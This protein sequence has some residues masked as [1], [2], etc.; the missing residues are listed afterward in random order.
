[1]IASKMH[2]TVL[3]ALLFGAS[4]AA[5]PSVQAAVD[6][7]PLSSTSNNGTNFTNA[8]GITLNVGNSA[9]TA[10]SGQA[11]A[12]SVTATAWSNT[13]SSGTVNETTVGASTNS[14]AYTLESAYLGWWSGNGYGVQNRDASTVSDKGDKSETGS[15]EHSVDNQQ[16]N[17]MVLF[18]FTGAVNLSQVVLGWSSTDADITV[19]AY[20]GANAPSLTGKKYG[21]LTTSG[22]S[23]IGHYDKSATGGST[24]V[25]VDISNGVFS[26]YWLIGAY[27]P[28]VGGSCST[29]DSG[30]DYVKIYAL[31]GNYPAPTPTP[32]PGVPEPGTLGLLGIGLLGLMRLRRNAKTV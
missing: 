31:S 23:L 28:Y 12:P 19:L 32:G 29:C 2:T 27:N 7:T 21:D 3:T 6:W 24:D 1:M 14:S 22:W 4:V 9:T 26:S 8:Q 11:N 5:V 20:T 13:N 10:G 17:D 15:T 16:R 30:D 25:S 18:S